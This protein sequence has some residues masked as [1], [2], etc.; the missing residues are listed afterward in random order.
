MKKQIVL[1]TAATLLTTYSAHATK[2]RVSALNQ[3]SDTGS[4]FIDDTRNVFRNAAYV[5]QFKNYILA[6]VGTADDGTTNPRAEGAFFRE[7]GAFTY[8]VYMGSNA[9]ED[10][11]AETATRLGVTVG[12]ASFLDSENEIDLFFGGDMGV[13]WGLRIHRAARSKKVSTAGIGE[14]TRDRLGLGL[15]M[16][17]GDL[18][19]YFNMSLKD[20]AVGVGS[21]N[22]TRTAKW[23]GDNMNLGVAYGWNAFTFYADYHKYGSEYT[24]ETAAGP[25]GERDVTALTFG[26]GHIKE[27]SSTS[28]VYG[29]VEYMTSTEE[30]KDNAAANPQNDEVKSSSLPVIVGFETD[31]ASWLTVRASA[32]QNFLINKTET[33][34]DAGATDTTT[35]ESGNESTTLG[36]GATLEFG[37]FKIDGT[38]ETASTGKLNSDEWLANISVHYWF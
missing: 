28:R 19:A 12:N 18:D 21:T 26:V 8:G 15:G 10:L 6:E 16:V 17:M 11:T 7:A 27:V 34:A 36:A 14:Q 33:K 37:K 9:H 29:N 20:E 23:E 22:P 3:D 35:E 25:K 13:E 31:A 38:L 24:D 4:H 2:A 5:N 1:A 32:K 30:V